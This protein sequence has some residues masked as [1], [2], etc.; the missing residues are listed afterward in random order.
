VILVTAAAYFVATFL[1]QQMKLRILFEILPVIPNGSLGF[2]PSDSNALVDGIRQIVST[3][4][5]ARQP[6]NG[7]GELKI[8]GETPGIKRLP[9]HPRSVITFLLSKSREG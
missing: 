6:A 9:S 8:L 7:A 4:I 3:R 1:G 2:H 5:A